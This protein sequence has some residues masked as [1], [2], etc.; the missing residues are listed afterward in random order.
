MSVRR[1]VRRQD[2]PSPSE[3]HGFADAT[4]LALIGGGTLLF[5]AL[6]SYTPDDVPAGFSFATK[7]VPNDPVTNIIGP[8]GVLVAGYLLLTFGG[9]AFLI[10]VCLIWLGLAR[11]LMRMPLTPRPATGFGLTVGCGSALLGLQNVIF[12]DWWREYNIFGPGGGVGF[13]VNRIAQNSI[14]TAGGILLCLTGYAAGI[15]MLLG[16]RLPVLLEGLRQSYLQL[17]AHFSGARAREEVEDDVNEAERLLAEQRKIERERRRLERE[18]RRGAVDPQP[19][20]DAAGEF[21][22]PPAFSRSGYAE[23]EPEPP[24]PAAAPAAEPRIIDGSARRASGGNR[25]SLSEWRKQQQ[26]KARQ[27]SESSGLATGNY[28]N[29]ILPPLELL[30]WDETATQQPAD[31]SYLRATQNNIIRTLA[32]FGIQV[33][34]G[35]ITRGP[36]ITRYEIYPSEGLRVSRISALEADLA[37]ATRAERIN[38]LAPIPGKDTVGIEIAN[39]DKVPV[40]LR[41]LLEDP[42]FSNSKAR[43]PLALGKDVYGDTI[44]ADLAGMPHLLVAGATGSGKSVCINSIIA[45][46]LFQFTPDQLR[47]IMV[48]PKVV[49]MQTYNDLPHLVVPVVTDPKKVLMALRWVVNE[50]EHRYRIF[51]QEG[52]RNFEAFNN[53]KKKAAEEAAKSAAEKPADAASEE[54]GAAEPV[55]EYIAPAGKDEDLLTIHPVRVEDDDDGEEEGGDIWDGSPLV[56][57]DDPEPDE[58]AVPDQIPYIVVIIDELADLMQTAPAD[59]EGLIARIAQKARAAGIHMIL[60]TQT[61]RAEVITGVIK[62]NIPCR[63]AFQVSSALDSRVIL[64]TKGADKLVGKGD[65]LYLPPGTAKMV[66]A[67]GAFVTDDEIFSLVKHCKEQGGGPRF[68]KSVDEAINGRSQP[69]EQLSDEDEETLQKCIDVIMQERK[70]STSLL[71]RRLRLGYGRAAR[72]MDLMEQRGIIGP[73]EGP[74]KPREILID[75]DEEEA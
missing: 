43:L 15:M 18:M 54:N 48:D 61:P 66:R 24:P 34:P 74:T 44:V 30:H 6:Y 5:L 38:I 52:V 47:F 45:S 22:P 39:K 19:A 4:A 51:A 17:R 33:T 56:A 70:A 16:L 42:A 57:A 40:P 36:T 65:M 21:T 23:D 13:L 27:A 58:E 67:Q 64:D 10:P 50:M 32:T 73:S 69:V 68:E 8:F 53:R 26:E 20:E 3:R 9:A 75:L 62:A 7:A 28:R 41:E 2:D 25:L 29:Y 1:P 11:L 60:A 35:D 37:R 72:M 12:T 55:A 46:L 63:I 49:E 31:V 71:Q 59:M 14:G